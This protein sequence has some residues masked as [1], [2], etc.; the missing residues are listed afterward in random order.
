MRTATEPIRAELDETTACHVATKTEPD[1]GKLQ[2]VEEHQEIPKEDAAV[3]P[4]RALRKLRRGR[5]LAAGRRQKPKGRIR[6]SCES[7]RRLT[8]AGRK[9]SRRAEMARRKRNVFKKLGPRECV[10]RGRD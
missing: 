7:S 10:V 5:N 6:A 8:V 4:V 3:M 9:V 2:F 1:P